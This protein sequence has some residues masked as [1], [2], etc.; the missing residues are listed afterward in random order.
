MPGHGMSRQKNTTIPSDALKERYGNDGNLLKIYLDICRC[1]SGRCEEADWKEYSDA[2]WQLFERLVLEEGVAALINS[3][4]SDLKPLIDRIPLESWLKFS[5]M[6]V[7][8]RYTN[9]M[10][11]KELSGNVFPAVLPQFQPV[12][13]LKGSALALALYEDIS[14]RDMCDTDLLVRQEFLDQASDMLKEAGYRIFIESITHL[15]P[16]SSTL[17]EDKHLSLKK[18]G[19]KGQLIELHWRLVNLYHKKDFD[20]DSWFFEHIMPIEDDGTFKN[21]SGLYMLSHTAALAHQVLHIYFCHNIAASSLF[22]FYET[23]FMAQKWRDLIDW[24]ELSYI[25]DKLGLGEILLLASDMSEELFG[26]ALPLRVPAGS[27]SNTFILKLRSQPMKTSAAKT[28]YIIKE[29]PF[30]EKLKFVLE[31]VF[32]PPEYMKKR[33]INKKRVSLPFLY[34]R[35]FSDGLKDFPK[36]VRA[37][38][39]KRS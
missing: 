6:R 4:K 34:L 17:I 20:L 37:L 9:E 13:M 25:F 28:L 14:L 26:A 31:A 33:Y 16:V 7:R 18:Q 21:V 35:R 39:A 11:Y 3:K 30:R 38:R 10:R 23:Y 19:A 5:T 8:I 2:D 27:D 12:I 1:L 36:F 29:L 24:D 15:R 22:H 32:P